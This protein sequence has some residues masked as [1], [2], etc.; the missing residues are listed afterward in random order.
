MNRWKAISGGT[1]VFYPGLRFPDGFHIQLLPKDWN[2][3][4]EKE[5]LLAELKAWLCFASNSARYILIHKFS[6]HNW[7]KLAFVAFF[8][9]WKQ[10]PLLSLTNSLQFHVAC[11]AGP[12]R[13]AR[14]VRI[15]SFFFAKRIL[16]FIEGKI[17]LIALKDCDFRKI[18]P[19]ARGPVKYHW[20]LH[21]LPKFNILTWTYIPPNRFFT[22]KQVQHMRKKHRANTCTI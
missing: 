10:I 6:P 9:A 15:L 8:I 13:I 22:G 12:G 17:G 7:T 21:S 11:S 18:P 16:P 2:D 20:K 14:I 19:K 3:F 5:L 4:L 1:M